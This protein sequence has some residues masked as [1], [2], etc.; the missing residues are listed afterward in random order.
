MARQLVRILIPVAPE[1]AGGERLQVYTDFGDGSIDLTRPLLADPVEVVPGGLEPGG[2]GVD[3]Y[4]D[5]PYGHGGAE[6]TAGGGYGLSPYGDAPY[7][8]G[9]VVVEVF[10]PV[11]AAYGVW[12]FAAQAVD[13]AGNEQSGGLVEVSEVVSATDPPRLDTFGLASYAAGIA[14]FDV[15]VAVDI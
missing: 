12:K 13:R 2:Y 10:V 3:A 15:A 5:A 8:M 9:E 11:R 6:A 7:G 4:G 14:T 1:W